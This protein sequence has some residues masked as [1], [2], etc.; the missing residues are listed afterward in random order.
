MDN[1]QNYKTWL[2]GVNAVGN[3]PKQTEQEKEAQ[4]QSDMRIKGYITSALDDSVLSKMI[5]LSLISNGIIPEGLAKLYFINRF[6]E[7]K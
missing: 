2:E 1:Y 3:Q 4:L 6:M 7:K 5:G